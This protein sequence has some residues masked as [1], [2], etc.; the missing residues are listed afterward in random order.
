MSRAAPVAIPPLSKVCPAWPEPWQWEQPLPSEMER[1]RSIGAR[2]VVERRGGREVFGVV[3]GSGAPAVPTVGDLLRRA[4]SLCERSVRFEV[5]G[6]EGLRVV[7]LQQQRV[8]ELNRKSRGPLEPGLRLNA[9]MAAQVATD[10]RRAL[11][12]GNLFASD[13]ARGGTLPFPHRAG[14]SPCSGP[15]RPATV[16]RDLQAWRDGEEFESATDADMVA[17]VRALIPR[18]MAREVKVSSVRD[19]R[20]ALLAVEGHCVEQWEAWAARA[21][22]SRREAVKVDRQAITASYGRKG[23]GWVP[24]ENLRVKLGAVG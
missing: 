10:A 9:S 5:K 1:S 14:S 23:R 15:V 7:A 3:I 11:R 18:T 22:R 8:R 13:F 4:Q 12:K 16:A 19:A 21:A 17:R 20:A 2:K 6:A 24:R